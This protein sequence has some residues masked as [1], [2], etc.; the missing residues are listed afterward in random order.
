[1]FFSFSL[2]V[3]EYIVKDLRDFSQNNIDNFSDVP[4]DFT[5]NLVVNEEDDVNIN[6]NLPVVKLY[7]LYNDCFPIR[8]KSMPRTRLLKPWKTSQLINIIDA[9][10]RIFRQYE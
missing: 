4:Q 8:W 3:N 1:M 5:I 9:K 6:V 7:R 2:H 10:F